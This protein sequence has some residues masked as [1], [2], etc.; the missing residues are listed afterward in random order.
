M[1]TN[2]DGPID[3][4]EGIPC[5]ECEDCEEQCDGH[6]EQDKIDGYHDWLE[7]REEEKRGK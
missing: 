3:P 7:A 6:E 1:R 4:P 2:W 5:D